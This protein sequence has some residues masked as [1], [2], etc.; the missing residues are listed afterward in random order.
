MGV[1]ASMHVCTVTILILDVCGCEYACMHCNNTY[2]G[3]VWLRD[4]IPKTLC[5]CAHVYITLR[6]YVIR[7]CEMCMSRVSL[8]P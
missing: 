3:C 1:G 8:V 7:I 4:S 6:Q 5:C 2:T